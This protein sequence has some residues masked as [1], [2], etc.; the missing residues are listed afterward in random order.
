M[1]QTE[2]GSETERWGDK[3]KTERQIEQRIEAK[4]T[5]EHVVEGNRQ[6]GR[7]R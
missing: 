1:R 6:N 5:R 3:R 2:R 4:A 7:P